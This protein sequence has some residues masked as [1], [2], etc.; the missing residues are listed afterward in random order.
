VF[1]RT[2][3]AV[4]VF[5]VAELAIFLISLTGDSDVQDWRVESYDIF[6]FV[7]SIIIFILLFK[8]KFQLLP[9]DLENFIF[10]YFQAKWKEGLVDPEIHKI[11][12]FVI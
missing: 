5:W 8:L 3:V 7:L 10:C 4:L 12:H 6:K 2:D 1:I 11:L 9:L